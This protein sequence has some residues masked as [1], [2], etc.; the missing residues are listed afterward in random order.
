[1]SVRWLQFVG[2]LIVLCQVSLSHAE[3]KVV[4]SPVY[5]VDKIYRSMT[6]PLTRQKIYLTDDRKHELLWITG[7]R[8]VMKG[9]DGKTPALQDFMCHS[10]LDFTP[11]PGIR[12]YGDP[13]LFTLSQGQ[14]SIQLPNGFGIPVWADIPINLTTQVLNLN[15]KNGIFNV[16][17]LV[18]I[19]F[20]READIR[21][22]MKPLFPGAAY[23]SKGKHEA[24]NPKS[25]TMNNTDKGTTCMLKPEMAQDIKGHGHWVV[26]PGRIASSSVATKI[27]NLPYDTTLHYVAVHVHPYAES[28]ELVDLTTKKTL[29]KSHIRNF[30]GK[31]G[32]EH[33][34]SFTSEKGIPVYKGHEYKITV[35]YNNPTSEDSDSM[36]VMYL[37]LLDKAFNISQYNQIPQGINLQNK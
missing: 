20:V 25:N 18:T 35:V 14:D 11:Q 8:A 22:P 32:I 26:K 19:E 16:R 30:K 27:M 29:F 12:Y 1:M 13:R 15:I 21:V 2:I 23:V 33:V 9:S 6:G 28:L 10:N 5:S 17:H 36:A 37:Y 7:Y 4:L 24:I 31:M 3:S 34:D